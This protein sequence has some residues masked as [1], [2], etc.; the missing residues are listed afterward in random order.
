MIVMVVGKLRVKTIEK[1]S[2]IKARIV[3]VRRKMH[4]QVVYG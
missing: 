3:R 1:G 2:E 4:K